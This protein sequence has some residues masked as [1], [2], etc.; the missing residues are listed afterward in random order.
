VDLQ[1]DLGRAALEGGRRELRHRYLAAR[2]LAVVGFPGGVAVQ[3]AGALDVGGH[4]GD[5]QGDALALDRRLPESLALLG[6]V[7]GRLDQELPGADVPSGDAQP[8]AAGTTHA[9]PIGWGGVWPMGGPDGLSGRTSGGGTER[10]AAACANGERVVDR[11]DHHLLERR[12]EGGE[13]AKRPVSERGEGFLVSLPCA[14]ESNDRGGPPDVADP[15]D[16]PPRP[17][18]E[19]LNREPALGW[20]MSGITIGYLAERNARKW[21]DR[22]AVIERDEDGRVAEFTFAEFDERA[23]R[24]AE[25]LAERG[26]EQRDTVAL[27]MKNNHEMLEAFV[28]IMKLGA[29]PVPVNHR[30]EGDAVTYVLSDSDTRVSIIDDL[31]AET[32]SGIHDDPETPVEH[33]L[34]VSADPPAHAESYHELLAAAS[35]DP[36]ENVPDRGDEAAIM[37]TSGTTGDPKGCVYTHD[38]LVQILQDGAFERDTLELHNRHLIAT[39]LFHVGAFVPFLQNFFVAG[40]TTVVDGFDPAQVLEILE[41]EAINSTY[42]VPTQTRMLLERDDLEE[43]DLSEMKSYGTGAAPVGA[44]LKRETMDR[45]GTDVTESFGQTEA[46]ALLLLPEYALEKPDSVGKPTLNLE[47]KVVDPDTGERLPPGEVGLI[48]YKGPS[49]IERYHNLPE[50]TEAAFD[51][52]GWFVSGDLVERDEDGFFSFVGRSDDMIVSGGENVHPAEI[53]DVLHGHPDVSAVAVI[54][55]P[56]ETW[57]ERIKASVVPTDGADL[58]EDGVIGYVGERLADYKRPREVEFFEELPRNPTGKVIK[59]KLE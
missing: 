14:G 55:V 47:A 38:N 21:P 18:R 36:V 52:D 9:W 12:P 59:A 5:W 27:Y 51:E 20:S 28:G 24:L 25:V 2:F 34:S 7:D 48:A 45:F 32:T 10:S 46:L 1:R 8:G 3:L 49:V 44:E 43:Y 31:G 29:L 13:R 39:P 41:A 50:K 11:R 56:D 53:E 30:F 6:V 40:A 22:E 17:S 35:G 23:D 37:Y 4:L 26:V 42:L 54:G 33:Y 57:G 58:T 16:E 15:P 19:R